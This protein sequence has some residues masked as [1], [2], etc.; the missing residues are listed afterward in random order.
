MSQL[1]NFIFKNRLANLV[2][3][4][5]RWYLFPPSIASFSQTF[6]KF[7]H[8][9]ELFVKSDVKSGSTS[10]RCSWFP[11]RGSSVG[12]TPRH[13]VLLF[14]YK[15]QHV[16]RARGK[17]RP[18]VKRPFSLL[19]PPGVRALSLSFLSL[20]LSLFL[21]RFYPLAANR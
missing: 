21:F 1:R 11:R 9:L 7:N 19:P 6:P 13:A 17:E 2:I 12:R 18:P 14:L 3:E 20:F 4:M 8:P 15:L 16:T 5:S 10:F